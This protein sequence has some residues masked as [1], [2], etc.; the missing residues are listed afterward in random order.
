MTFRPPSYAPYR[1]APRPNSADGAMG[2]AAGVF[3]L[4]AGFGYGAFALNGIRVRRR[5]ERDYELALAPDAG[6]QLLWLGYG[7]AAIT[8]LV[9][10]VFLL[11]RTVIGRVLVM[12]GGG[13]AIAGTVVYA[14]AELIDSLD[15]V[16]M[17]FSMRIFAV[18]F[19]LAFTGPGVALVAMTASRPVGR[20]IRRE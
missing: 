16:H 1:P 8:L 4:L 12:I 6:L 10:A 17:S 18:L 5:V 9:G 13:F 19:T 11:C 15:S 2:I 7:L 14:L 3:A 20:W